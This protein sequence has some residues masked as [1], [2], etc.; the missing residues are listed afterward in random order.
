MR[1]RL[2]NSSAWRLLAPLFLLPRATSEDAAVYTEAQVRSA[3]VELRA[4]VSASVPRVVLHW[5]A[6]PYPVTGQTVSRRRAGTIAWEFHTALAPSA[7]SWNDSSA[8]GQT[9]YEYRVERIHS[10]PL[11]AVAEG[12][13]WSGAEVPAVEDRGRI[14]LA[15]DATMAVPLEAELDRLARDLTGDGWEVLRTDVPR[16][17][18]PAQARDAIRGWYA[19]DPARTRA[20][21]LVGRIPVAYSGQICPDGHWDPPPQDHHRGAWP[22]DAY[23]GDMDGVWTDSSVNYTVANMDG[24][25]NHNVPGDGKFD[26]SLLVGEHLPE[27]AVGRIDLSNLGGISGGLS[28][29]ELLRRYLDRLHAF[30]H[31]EGNFAAL[32][33][34]ALVDDTKFGPE[35][36]FPAAVSGWTSGVA[37]FGPSNTVAGDWV[38]ALLDQDYLVAY[39]FGPGEFT[40]AEGVGSSADFRDTRCR[41][42]FNLLFGSFFGDWDSTDNYLRAPLAARADSSGLVSV[43]S[44]VPAWRLFPLAAGGTMVDA[45]R[46]VV[47][48]VN[49]PDGPFPPTDESWTNPDQCHVAI[50]GDPTLRSHPAKP[51]TGLNGS[52]SGNEVTLAWS[53]PSGE[54]NRLGC[55]IYR[56][57]EPFGPF[58][59]TGGQTSAGAAGFVDVPPRAGRWYY[60]VRSVKQ[61]TTASASY[62]NLS[63]GNVVEIDVPTTGYA[64]W[65]AGMAD[66]GEAADPNGDGISNLLAYALGASGENAS[67]DEILP[68]QEGQGF[69]VPYSG[70]VDLIY[71][72]E[73]SLNLSAWFVVARKNLGNAWALNA[74]SGYPHQASMTL[75]S[76]G[77]SAWRFADA[78]SLSR[79]FWR[80]R[81]TR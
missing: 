25:R 10:S 6:S 22:T 27:M 78:T 49:Q 43:W 39:G 35:F 44:G 71:E 24:S 74:A 41:A 62:D 32:G 18:T 33:Q 29:T 51:V 45:Y 69:L 55:R 9:L 11:G 58:V 63:Q 23:Y 79:G 80:L 17:A 36:G 19:L 31:R 70:R 65:S 56:S 21:L 20:V 34:R 14:I 72:I 50:M 53:N 52:V 12:W 15:V 66:P 4:G 38:P 3:A 2:A 37:L 7:V 16:T 60:M 5:N 77:G 81:V 8:A 28:E 61:E 54:A 1:I 40:G 76:V 48:E 46:H 68:R 30:R 59:R 13:V 75:S 67:T 73:R 57:M 26:V 64:A 42:V 47:R